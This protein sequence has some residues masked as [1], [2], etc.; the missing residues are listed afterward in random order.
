MTNCSEMSL[1]FFGITHFRKNASANPLE[2]HTFKTK[3]LKSFRFIHF[4]KRV[5]G[6]VVSETGNCSL[7]TRIHERTLTAPRRLC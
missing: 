4:Q 2:S 1:K 7:R 5:G 3:D 6:G